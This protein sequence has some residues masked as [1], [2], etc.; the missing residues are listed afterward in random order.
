MI[1][2]YNKKYALVVEPN[3]SSCG[4]V[5]FISFD[6]N[7][8]VVITDPFRSYYRGYHYSVLDNGRVQMNFCVSVLDGLVTQNGKSNDVWKHL[9]LSGTFDLELDVQ[10]VFSESQDGKVGGRLFSLL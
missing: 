8:Y 9:D 7:G 5:L 4:T 1:R 2:I 6:E 3:D 10:D